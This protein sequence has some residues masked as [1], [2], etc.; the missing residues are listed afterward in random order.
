MDKLL[1]MLGLCARAGKLIT[2]EKA[3]VQ[4]VRTGSACAAVLDG[5]ASEN[6][7][8]AVGQACQ[9]HGVPLV[10]T[11]AFALGDAIGKPSR[12]AAAITDAGF[13]GRILQLS[14][15]GEQARGER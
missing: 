13:A 8:K 14:S 15:S 10:R 2:G 12:M 7:V 4:A 1:S 5:A 9:T 3:V 11:G 6:A